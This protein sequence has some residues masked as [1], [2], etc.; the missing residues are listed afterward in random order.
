MPFWQFFRNRLIGWIGHALLVQPSKTAHRIFFL[1]YI[2]IFIYF[3]KYETIVR[4]SAWSFG[5]SDPDPSSVSCN[6][7]IY[8][9][10]QKIRFWKKLCH[11]RF[12]RDFKSDIVWNSAALGTLSGLWCNEATQ[13]CTSTT[14]T[15]EI[16]NFIC[17][18]YGLN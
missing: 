17:K 15:S 2:L 12:W 11:S 6:K 5:H 3:F 4:S 10:M 8:C 14:Q 16:E 18:F 9:K 1:F 7:I 13:N